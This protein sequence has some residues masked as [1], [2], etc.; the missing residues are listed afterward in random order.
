M[1][2]LVSEASIGLAPDSRVDR[3]A[4]VIRGA[5]VVGTVSRNGRTYPADLLR[6]RF[7]VYEGAQV[8]ADHDYAQLKTGR[9]RPLGQWGG[10]IRGAHFRGDGVYADVHCLKETDA[11]R[12]I[13][14]AAARMPEKFGLSPFHQIESRKDGE[15]EVVTAILDVWSVDAVTRPATTRTLFEAEDVTM[16]DEAPNSPAPAAAAAGAAMSV[17]QAFLA[18]QNAVMASEDYDDNEKVQVLRDVMKL[19]A[20]IL[21]NG[22]EEAPAESDEEAPA[23]E[24]HRRPLGRTA[25]AIAELQASMRAITIRQMAGESLQLD[26]PTMAALLALPD[27][28]AVAVQ[29]ENIKWQRRPRYTAGAPRATGRAAGQAPAPAAIPRLTAGADRDAVRRFYQG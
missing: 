19:K 23:E 7:A 29:L 15:T 4:G 24:S 26:A 14:E 17:E 8:Y 3:E 5:K 13:L 20:K 2:H 27:D 9:A 6:A 18:L 21:G 10:V 16:P 25:R 12:I 11:G 22:E 28:A 1:S